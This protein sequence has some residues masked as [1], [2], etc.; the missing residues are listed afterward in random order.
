M[1]R[2]QCY[3]ARLGFLAA[4]ASFPTC[5]CARISGYRRCC[6]AIC[7]QAA[8]PRKGLAVRISSSRSCLSTRFCPL[9]CRPLVTPVFHNLASRGVCG[10]SLNPLLPCRTSRLVRPGGVCFVALYA[11]P[12]LSCSG[13]VC[14]SCVPHSCNF[15]GRAAA[16]RGPEHAF[17]S[18]PISLPKV[19]LAKPTWQV[20]PSALPASVQAGCALRAKSSS[21]FDDFHAAAHG[22]FSEDLGV[23]A[24]EPFGSVFGRA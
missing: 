6:K 12:D 15:P 3:Q 18:Y 13:S 17:A 22:H 20:T 9:S 5:I 7:A 10:A 2:V 21:R 1:F 16:A 11:N 8:C 24:L 14:C 19:C 4:T 23:S